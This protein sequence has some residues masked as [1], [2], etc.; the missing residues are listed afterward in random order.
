MSWIYTGSNTWWKSLCPGY[1][2]ECII[3][4]K[5]KCLRCLKKYEKWEYWHTFLN[6]KEKC[7]DK[8]IYCKECKFILDR[9]NNIFYNLLKRETASQKSF[10][11]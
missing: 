6:N 10:L 1:H 11:Y 3:F 5:P 8:K 2:P 4:Q 9:K 7:Y